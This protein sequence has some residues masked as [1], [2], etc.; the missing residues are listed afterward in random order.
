MLVD[1]RMPGLSGVDFLT[2]ARVLY[3][4][5][6]GALLTADTDAA[7]KA[8]N[9]VHLDYYLMKLWDPPEDRLY[10]VLDDLLGDWPAGYRPTFEGIRLVGH[11]WSAQSHA[12]RDFLARNQ[13]PFC[14]LDAAT[15]PKAQELLT[16]ACPPKCDPTGGGLSGRR[17]PPKLDHAGAGRKDRV[18][19][20]R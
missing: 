14:W 20:P 8:I 2:Q 18:A 3:P 6:K 17:G 15:D 19:R 12:T 16:L 10:P 1:Q 4:T 13:V 9:E 7:I 11:R 5:A